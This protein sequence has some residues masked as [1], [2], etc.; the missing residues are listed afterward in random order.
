MA[1]VRTAL[2]AV[3]GEDRSGLG[4]RGL[5]EWAVILLFVGTM[6]AGATV[7]VGPH[8]YSALSSLNLALGF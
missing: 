5:E 6:L 1:M 8:L 4:E 2:A 3:V 7:T